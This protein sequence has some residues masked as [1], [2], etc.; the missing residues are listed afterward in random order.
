MIVTFYSYKGG[1]GR[2]ML[3]ANVADWLSSQSA[4]VLM[5]DWDLEAPGLETYFCQSREKAEDM[6]SGPGVID[7][8]TDYQQRFREVAGKSGNGPDICREACERLDGVERYLQTVPINGSTLTL[9]PA[10]SRGRKELVEGHP[11]QSLETTSA[12]SIED[13]LKE[14]DESPK[15]RTFSEYAAAVQNFNWDVFFQA[16]QGER[17]FEW[18]RAQLASKFDLVLIDSRTGV[19]EMG[20]VCTR[21]LADLVVCCVAPNQQN[22]DGSVRMAQTFRRPDVLKR[23]GEADS[24]KDFEPQ[25][26]RIERA[27]DPNDGHYWFS[28]RV[29]RF[30]DEPLSNSSA[31]S[32]SMSAALPK[33]TF[34][35]HY[36]PYFPKLSYG[37]ALT[38]PHPGG[39][40]RVIELPDMQAKCRRL[41]VHIVLH[42]PDGSP[43]RNKLAAAVEQEAPE[44]VERLA[45]A[46]FQTDQERQGST[47]RTKLEAAGFR[48]H[49]DIDHRDGSVSQEEKTLA[50]LREAR[51]LLV[52][53]SP[54]AIQ[55]ST[56]RQE[57][58]F[59]RQMGKCVH[60]VTTNGQM[61]PAASRW[62]GFG[63]L[64]ELDKDWER[65]LKD[66][67]SPCPAQRAPNMTPKVSEFYVERLAEQHTLRSR[68]LEGA[69]I[70]SP[71]LLSIWGQAGMGKTQL[72]ARV[73]QEEGI[74]DAFPGGILWITLD[75]APNLVNG[76]AEIYSA[77]TGHVPNFATEDIAR[78][79]ISDRLAGRRFLLV[80]DDVWDGQHLDRLPAPKGPSVTLILTRDLAVVRTNSICLT[81]GP[82]L[83][84]ES[85]TLVARGLNR[86]GPLAE[87][88]DSLYRWP[89]LLSLARKAIGAEM[90]RGLTEAKAIEYA[91]AVLNR[92]G[93][94]AFD[95]VAS[96]ERES[97]SASLKRTLDALALRERDWEHLS[98]FIRGESSDEWTQSPLFNRLRNLQFI[99]ADSNGAFRPASLFRDYLEKQGW[100][101]TPSRGN[102]SRRE[103]SSAKDHEFNE[104]VQDVRT[105]LESRRVTDAPAEIKET[106][107][108]LKDANYFDYARKYAALVRRDPALSVHEKLHDFLRHQ[109]ALCTYKDPDLPVDQRLDRALE[110]L[111][112]PDPIDPNENLRDTTDPETLGIA[113][114]IHKTKWKF[115]G[116]KHHLEHALDYYLR[117]YRSGVARDFGYTGINAAFI[118]DLLACQE[119]TGQPEI[120]LERLRQATTI[121]QSLFEDLPRLPDLLDKDGN[122][123]DRLR[124]TWW[125]LATL[126]EV[127]FGLGRFERARYWLREARAV[128]VSDWEYRSTAAQFIHLAEA[129]K[130]DLD[131]PGSEAMR[132]LDVLLDGDMTTIGNLRRGKVGLALSG[133]GFRASLF[134]IGVLARLAELDVLKQVEVLSC[135]S[136]G[137]VVGAHY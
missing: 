126:A 31:N 2:S 71:T 47:L 132:T 8:L 51:G 49:P 59:A 36:I 97:V 62:P 114:A 119:E 20:G 29:F 46:Y 70:P 27:Q 105:A 6:Q 116:Q 35:K 41:G 118:L 123:Q 73:C 81:L 33:Y 50:I 14:I 79:S 134:H 7:L 61:A 28:T 113:G 133:G 66:L 129:Q 15:P 95:L 21:L 63:S 110:I 54:A 11:R 10:G 130:M 76:L 64:Y 12:P 77:L 13:Y 135:V 121:R 68:L 5:I 89:L 125:F 3:L 98:R 109:H 104:A 87:L 92:Q 26:K 111:D 65:L 42:A 57:V 83:E 40:A 115:D 100:V 60:T 94:T 39:P 43:L 48:L 9:M 23:R 24:F 72:A 101:K 38:F 1:V 78:A 96:S 91:T 99:E 88:K 67:R 32:P 108:R 102:P 106:I 107:K 136:G 19:T 75:K 90:A 137:S 55:S 69:N 112:Q 122:R 18:L 131:S 127:C 34:W 86:S 103:F 25:F 4:R 58:R 17:F 84:D 30:E 82:M 80:I 124:N 44:F 85:L 120:A 16:F 37:E 117:G 128:S 74:V 93:P 22:L 53:L 56:L 45:L 52:L